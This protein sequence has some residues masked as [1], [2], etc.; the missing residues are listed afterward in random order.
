MEIYTA[1]GLMSGSSLD[2][3]DIAFCEFSLDSTKWKFKIHQAETF[4]YD[5]EWLLLLKELPQKSKEEIEWANIEYGELTAILV[6][7]FIEEYNLKP[8]LIASHGH[9][10]LHEPAKGYTLQIGNGQT[11]ANNTN[12]K[13]ICD[14]RSKDVSL[15]GQGA[16]LVPIGDKYLFG[17]F[18]FCLNIGGIANISIEEKG[19]MK[20]FDIC[21][22]NQLLNHLSLQAGKPYDE[23]GSIAQMG[24]MNRNLFNQLNSDNYFNLAP[25]KSLSNQYVIDNFISLLDSYQCPLEDKLLTAVKHIAYQI[26]ETIKNI[27]EGRLLI[28]GGGAHNAFLVQ[29]LR[30]ETKHEIV[31][32][33][34]KIIDFKEAL[35]FA[36]MGVLRNLEM[37]NCL[38][39]VTGAREDSSGGQVFLP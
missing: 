3:L 29:A 28:S 18:D 21:G 1:L 27:P 2:G 14:F 23:N 6:N 12:I 7:N 33:N 31:I 37:T 35:I 30:R 17:D 9:T 16:P 5:E 22:A 32:P 13:T 26:N 4:A 34:S 36:F 15:G 39:T 38:A 24:K 8:D 20:A 10:I 25:P 11:I 19:Q